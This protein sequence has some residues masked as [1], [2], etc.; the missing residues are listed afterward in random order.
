M[1]RHWWIDAGFWL[2]VYVLVFSIKDGL[3]SAV[4]WW[5]VHRCAKRFSGFAVNQ[6]Q[7]LCLVEQL[8][9]LHLIESLVS[10]VL[11]LIVW[12]AGIRNRGHW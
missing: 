10:G 8:Y 5:A 7:A 9:F 12:Y 4:E 11:A 6:E 1:Q 2:W 3:A